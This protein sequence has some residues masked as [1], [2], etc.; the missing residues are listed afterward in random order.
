MQTFGFRSTLFDDINKLSYEWKQLENVFYSNTVLSKYSYQGATDSSILKININAFF[1]ATA[2]NGGPFALLLNNKIVPSGSGM[3]KD[4]IFVMSAYGDK[5]NTIEIKKVFKNDEDLS[6]R[7]WA[8][9][10]FTKEEDILLISQTGVILILDPM[11]GETLHRH[12]FKEQ[13]MNRNM[14]ENCKYRDNSIIIKTGQH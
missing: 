3:F 14:I 4:K 5:I 1:I 8:M 2:K 9:F 10:E 13:F 11:S 7:H 12:D 6:I